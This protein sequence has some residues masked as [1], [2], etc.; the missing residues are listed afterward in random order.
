MR[1]RP[2]LSCAACGAMV[3]VRIGAWGVAAGHGGGERRAVGGVV[4]LHFALLFLFL[5]FG[6]REAR[7][8]GGGVALGRQDWDGSGRRRP[9]QSACAWRRGVSPR[10]AGGDWLRAHLPPPYSF[11]FFFSCLCSPAPSPSLM[12]IVS[13]HQARSQQLSQLGWCMRRACTD[14]RKDQAW[15]HR[16]QFKSVQIV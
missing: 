3:G 12:P 7:G 16:T 1:T 5:F 8:V 6:A 11:F 2:V 14:V 10:P 4:L 13:P 15:R 9:P